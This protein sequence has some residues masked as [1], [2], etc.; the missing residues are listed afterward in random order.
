MSDDLIIKSGSQSDQSQ[1]TGKQSSGK[2]NA[3]SNQVASPVNQ[4]A[5]NPAAS[6]DQLEMNAMAS[7]KTSRKP[8]K[9]AIPKIVWDKYPDLI[10]LIKETESMD[11]EER[12]YWFQVLPIMT[13]HQVE[14]FKKILITEKQQLA[15][16]DKEYEQELQKL[17]EKHMLEWKEF[18]VKEKRAEL[19]QK[20]Q[21]HEEEEED[22]EAELLAKLS[23]I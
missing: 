12:E 16:L 18:E 19:E 20:E 1:N 10:K 5:G 13:D 4:S 3:N 15:E 9:Y 8:E 14:K 6:S 21:A 2:A 23:Q 22:V 11:D 17:N 7:A